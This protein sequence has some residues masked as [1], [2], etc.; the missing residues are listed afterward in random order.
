MKSVFEFSQ[1]I[2][3]ELVTKTLEE[4]R[5]H[6]GLVSLLETQPRLEDVLYGRVPGET[7]L[8]RYTR[9][10]RIMASVT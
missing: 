10:N 4:I 2:E 5:R 1:N 9:D 7:Q 6:D 3:E 8:H